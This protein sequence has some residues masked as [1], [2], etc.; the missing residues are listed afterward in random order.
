MTPNEQELLLRIQALEAENAKFH[1]QRQYG[2][3]WED[4]QEDCSNIY[5]SAVPVLKLEK[6]L[7]I[8][9]DTSASNLPHNLFIEGD[10]YHALTALNYTHK[11]MVDIIYVD[12]PYNTGNK[13]EFRYNDHWVDDEDTYR[14]SKWISFMHRR[15]QLSKPLLKDTGVIFVSIGIDE[16]ANLRL[17]MDKVF[18]EQ[19]FLACITRL[20]KTTSNK[21]TYFAPSLDYVLVYA[22]NKTFLPG[23]TENRSSD[24]KYIKG[25]NKTQEDGRKFK[26]VGLYQAALD[27]RPNQRY[28]IKC[29]DGSVCIPPGKVFPEDK[30]DSSKVTPLSNEDKVW[31]WSD[32]TYKDKKG[33]GILVFKKTPASPLIDGNGERS[34]WNVYV[35]Q[36]LDESLEKGTVPR[37]FLNIQNS[38]GTAD[39]KALDLDDTFA[40]PKPVELMKHL[41]SITQNKEAVVLDFFAGS[42][43]MAQAVLELNIDDGGT[44]QFIIC[45]NNENDIARE[46]THH[47][48]KRVIAGFQERNAI[49]ANMAYFTVDFVKKGSIADST[50]NSLQLKMNGLIQAHEDA[51]VE[52]NMAGSYNILASAQGHVVGILYDDDDMDDFINSLKTNVP[53]KELRLY[54]FSL[55]HDDYASDYLEL[56]NVVSTQAFPENILKAYKRVLPD[57]ELASSN[58][59][60]EE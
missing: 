34:K 21:G 17:L 25:F 43:T 7:S 10:N 30:I 12:P 59:S 6:E 39:L 16:L 22:K 60:G 57:F 26:E 58:S 2:L 29:P 11:N 27:S 18:G 53:D 33:E 50:R 8:T 55:G 46:V 36:F 51:F 49:P 13:K 23:F 40:F 19:N 52:I 45:T 20:S 1:S 5:A 31:R 44:R 14:H 41:L 42:G 15:L 37:D 35:K 32:V 47:R 28:Y 38:K 9:M 56:S 48:I 24:E 4:S 3:V 54:T